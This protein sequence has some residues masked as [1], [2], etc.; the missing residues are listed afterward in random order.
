MCDK[1]ALNVPYEVA[2]LNYKKAI[3]DGLLNVIA[4]MGISTLNSYYGAQLFDTVCLNKDFLDEYFSG[5]P[6]SIE[7]DGI[8]EIEESLLKRHVLGFD[9]IEPSLDFGGNLRHRKEGEWHAWSISS[10]VAL[11]KFIRDGD[12]KTY[13]EFSRIANER[14]VFIRHLLGYK[15]SKPITLEEVE[16]EEHI[17][18]RFFSGAMS[19]GALSPEAHETIAEAC[20][21]LGIKSNSGEGGEDAVRY[22]TIKNSAIKQIASGRFGVTPAYLA[23]ATDLEIKIAQGAQNQ[24]KAVIFPQIK[25]QNILP[26]SGT[27]GR[28]VFSY[29]RRHIMIFIQ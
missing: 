15:T 24:G 20:N 1:G 12:Y 5:T 27:V 4:R 11:N 23:S 10:V 13:K 28:I 16:S 7:S 21:R 25:L 8:V 19:V 22:G 2:A 9:T 3:E 29:H 14:P 17:L 6:V 26:C 18:K